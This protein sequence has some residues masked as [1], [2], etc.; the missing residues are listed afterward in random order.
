MRPK[1]EGTRKATSQLRFFFCGHLTGAK[2]PVE[3]I[4][5]AGLGASVANSGAPSH[6]L[7]HQPES[8]EFGEQAG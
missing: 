4:S 7:S 6:R 5:Y 3:S 8:G 1:C 2:L